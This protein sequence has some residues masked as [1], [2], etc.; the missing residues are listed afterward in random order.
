MGVFTMTK[1]LRLTNVHNPE[2]VVECVRSKDAVVVAAWTFRQV[3]CDP[4][5]A[6]SFQQR[7]DRQE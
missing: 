6:V 7:M 2:I 1:M 3:V 4:C 5:F